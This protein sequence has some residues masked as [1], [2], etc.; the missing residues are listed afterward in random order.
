MKILIAE[1]AGFCMGVRRVVDLALDT[2]QK[3]PETIYTYG[4][5]IHNKQ[6][7]EM[8]ENRGA[9]VLDPRNLPANPATILLRAHGVPPA[10][11]E[12]LSSRGHTIIDGTCPKVKTVH[13]VIE[14]YREQGFTIVITGDPGH[15]EV[16]GLLSYAGDRSHLIQ[17]VEDIATLP[18]TDSICLVSQTTFDRERFEVIARKIRERY[19]G[20]NVVVKKTICAAT[21][22]RQEETRKLSRQVDCMIVVGG[23]NSANT[24]RL[25]QISHETGT[26]TY[27]VESE[28]ELPHDVCRNIGTVGITAGASTPHWMI[29]RVVEYLKMLEQRSNTNPVSLFKGFLDVCVN[30]N[31]IVASGAAAL[32]YAASH[33]QNLPVLLSGA[34]ATFLYFLSM[35]LFNSL[36]SFE[37]THHHGI[38]R[39]RFYKAHRPL[40]FVFS[41]LT[42]AILLIHTFFISRSVFFFML[43]ATMA[44]SLY[45]FT[46]VPRSLQKY[47][48]YRTLKDIPTSRDLFVSLAWASVITVLPQLLHDTLTIWTPATLV[49]FCWVFFLVYVRS[50][51]FDMRDIEGDRIMGRETLVTILGE[52]RIRNGLLLLLPMLCLVLLFYPVL[53][54]LQQHRFGVTSI[55]FVAQIP[56]LAYIYFVL[57]A[58]RTIR[59]HHAVLFSVLM[60]GQFFLAALFALA[61]HGVLAV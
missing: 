7:V 2:T 14:K 44:G 31:V 42:I 45:H 50:L 8:L 10:I 40:L 52:K 46:I 55:Y 33:L 28:Q 59:L 16:V 20:K 35:Y 9:R 12:S 3:S 51:I 36:S 43:F 18:Q 39:Y 27:H 57:K 38:S 19:D 49:T 61:V 5:I 60:D 15:A 25:A 22:H 30:L 6:A 4:P 47:L 21:K 24:I 13:K 26:P 29:H 41:G 58:S 54:L 56:V 53:L 17:R 48:K 11:Q 32:F 37:M 34:V 1:T 23:K